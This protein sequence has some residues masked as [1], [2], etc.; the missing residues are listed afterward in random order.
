[1]PGRAGARGQVCDNSGGVREGFVSGR[2]EAVETGRGRDPGDIAVVAEAARGPD[3]RSA[4]TGSLGIICQTCGECC[5]R[6]RVPLTHHDLA[7]LVRATGLSPSQIAE[8]LS[9]DEIDMTGEP[10]TF[11]RLRPGRR[12]MVLRHEGPGC[13]F[14]SAERCT[15]HDQRP[16][17]CAAYPF[18]F[19]LERAA[20]SAPLRLDGAPCAVAAPLDPGSLADCVRTLRAEL[21]EYAGRVVVW[22]RRQRLRQRLLRL[23]EGAAAFYAYLGVGDARPDVTDPDHRGDRPD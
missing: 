1:M 12:L 20:Q 21:A 6:V 7:R 22:N 13:R 18:D 14:L 3:S 4:V 2:A 9:G 5:R 10:E 17:A 8:W 19:D 11:V 16:L 15:V 23:P